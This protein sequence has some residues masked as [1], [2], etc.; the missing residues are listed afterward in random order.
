MFTD[1]M[2]GLRDGLW[3]ASPFMTQVLALPLMKQRKDWSATSPG[4]WW[5]HREPPEIGDDFTTT[6]ACED[7]HLQAHRFLATLQGKVQLVQQKRFLALEALRS[8]EASL[9]GQ[10]HALSLEISQLTC[11]ERWFREDSERLRERQ[12][13]LQCSVR[14][15]QDAQGALLEQRSSLSSKSQEMDRLKEQ[16]AQW[17]EIA[18]F[19]TQRA[20]E[21]EL[22]LMQLLFPW[23]LAVRPALDARRSTGALDLD[24]SLALSRRALRRLRVDFEPQDAEDAAGVSELTTYLANFTKEMLGENLRN[25][26]DTDIILSP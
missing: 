6:E 20:K 1:K 9:L 11:Q 15:L 5:L 25:L 2:S 12:R 22:Q 7:E 18:T 21:L 13:Q 3:A 14:E 24:A 17:K 19:R 26:G 10:C 4:Q 8:K 23:A 16:L